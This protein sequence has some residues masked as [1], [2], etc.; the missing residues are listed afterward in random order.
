M[1]KR[2]LRGK[3]VLEAMYPA[4][5]EELVALAEAWVNDASTVI[6]NAIWGGF[7]A[8]AANPAFR[9]ALADATDDLERGITRLLYLGID[10]LLSGDEPFRAIHGNQE[11]ES[12]KAAP[13]RPREYDIG[14]AMR[15]NPRVVWP[16]EAKVLGT[17]MALA[18]YVRTVRER[19]LTCD[20]APFV[21]E[22]AMA[23]YLLSGTQLEAFGAIAKALKAQLM[24]D[25][26]WPNRDHRVSRHRRTVPKATPYPR[27]FR[28]HHLML[29]VRF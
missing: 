21:S 12:R 19:F 1:G 3:T 20:Y 18:D 4:A 8:L 29:R 22:G 11:D 28:C 15:S 25:P 17:P 9:T 7:D 5:P 6:M 24:A 14:F 26:R 2:Q 13:A 27:V 10:D 23:G 16:L